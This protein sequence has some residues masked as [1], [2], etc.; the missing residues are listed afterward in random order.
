VISKLSASASPAR[1]WIDSVIARAE[2]ASRASSAS[3]IDSCP[4][5]VMSGQPGTSEYS[6]RGTYRMHRPA[7]QRSLGASVAWLMIE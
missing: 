5:T 7:T 2:S 6:D 4:A 1:R 3:I